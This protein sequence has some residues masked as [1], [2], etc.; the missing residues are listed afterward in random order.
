MHPQVDQMV[1]DEKVWKK[2]YAK[3]HR[4]EINL[5]MREYYQKNRLKQ[6][7]RV[8]KWKENNPEK[9][10]AYHNSP[11]IKEKMRLYQKKYR[12]DHKDHLKKYH[13]KYDLKRKQ[14]SLKI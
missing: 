1:F 11:A 13:K 5:Y 10:N 4:K 8:K 9:F 7:I 2:E 12:E 6:L 14:E 3:K